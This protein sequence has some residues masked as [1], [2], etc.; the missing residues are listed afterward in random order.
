MADYLADL[1]PSIYVLDYD[2]NVRSVEELIA[3]HMPMCRKIRAK[4][5]T[6][7]IILITIEALE[8]SAEK[9]QMHEKREVIYNNYLTLKAEGDENIYFI[10]GRTLL[11]DE[12]VEAGFADLLH[13]NDLGYYRIAK[14]LKPLLLEILQKTK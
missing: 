11:G 1:D 5:P 3:S 14:S 9:M 6:T 2:G 7:P 12:D 8:R 13:P 4:H 10:D